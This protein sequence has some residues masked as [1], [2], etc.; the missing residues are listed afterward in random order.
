MK[1]ENAK[2]QRTIIDIYG[3]HIFDVHE[4]ENI[5]E[6]AIVNGKYVFIVYM[7]QNHA[8]SLIYTDSDTAKLQ[9]FSL[10]NLW[11]T[12]QIEEEK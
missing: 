8:Q 10:W 1:N 2:Y 7:L 4:I 9:R 3:K 11:R 12:W 6:V 5:S